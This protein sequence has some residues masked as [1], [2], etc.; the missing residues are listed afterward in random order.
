MS[1]DGN[2]RRH[3]HNIR[4]R[5]DASTYSH[6]RQHFLLIFPTSHIYIYFLKR[7]CGEGAR[8]AERGRQQVRASTGGRC[9][10]QGVCA[11]ARVLIVPF[12]T[13]KYASALVQSW[14]CASRHAPQ[15]IRLSDGSGI[16]VC[17]SLLALIVPLAP[18]LLA[19]QEHTLVTAPTAQQNRTEQNRT[20][21]NRTAVEVEAACCG[22]SGVAVW[23]YVLSH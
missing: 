18:R 4:V 19:S 15:F 21:Q 14:G 17:T 6:H 20:E 23:V 13:H 7:V 22:A 16:E 2:L 1:H 3:F 9:Q 10:S 12:T 11:C 8:R 5:H